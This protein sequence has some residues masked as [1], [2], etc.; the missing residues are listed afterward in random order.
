MSRTHIAEPTLQVQYR[1]RILTMHPMPDTYATEICDFCGNKKKCDY[2]V[3]DDEEAWKQV[4]YDICKDCQ[5]E[6]SEGKE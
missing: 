2:Y 6:I 1:D 5:K 4:S 3:S